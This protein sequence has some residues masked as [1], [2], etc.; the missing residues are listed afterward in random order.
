MITTIYAWQIIGAIVRLKKQ[1]KSCKIPIPKKHIWKLEFAK[2]VT[3]GKAEVEVILGN[4]KRKL[5]L[6]AKVN[7]TTR[8]Y[9][10]LPEEV[11]P[12]LNDGGDTS[13]YLSV[14]MPKLTPSQ[15]MARYREVVRLKDAGWGDLAIATALGATQGFVSNTYSKYKAIRDMDP[16]SPL[17]RLTPPTIS[18]LKKVLGVSNLTFDVLKEKL[19]SE[20]D[21]WEKR[22]VFQ[23]IFSRVLGPISEVR[24]F[25]A[26]NGIKLKQFSP[27]G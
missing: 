17:L 27:L 22:M 20:G 4:P 23:P 8:P 6:T 3:S 19:E 14:S 7:F 10:E 15:R 1:K 5:E 9:L 13:V 24:E 11:R 18:A 16:N 12:L 21:R 2:N 26:E 25:C